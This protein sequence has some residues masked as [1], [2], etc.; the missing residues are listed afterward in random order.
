M[1]KR[2]GKSGNIFKENAKQHGVSVAEVMR[3]IQEAI[4]EAWNNPD[5]AIRES[6]RKMFPNGKPS[7]EEFIKAM[8]KQMKWE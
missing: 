6:Q 3:D 4:D 2:K 7:I 5:P 1:S 8:A